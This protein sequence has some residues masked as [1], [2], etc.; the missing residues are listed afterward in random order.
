MKRL[1]LVII[2]GLFFFSNCSKKDLVSPI[3]DPGPSGPVILSED[4]FDSYPANTILTNNVILGSLWYSIAESNQTRSVVDG[5]IS[6]SGA[7]SIRLEAINSN[8]SCMLLNLGLAGNI[9]APIFIEGYCRIT[10]ANSGI[11]IAVGNSGEAGS[12][13]G[14]AGNSHGGLLFEVLTNDL[15]TGIGRIAKTHTSPII[16]RSWTKFLIK[17]DVVNRTYSTWINGGDQQTGVFH[18]PNSGIAIDYIG[19]ALKSANQIG[20]YAIWYDSIKIYK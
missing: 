17:I 5:T 14:L 11:A 3:T 18:S 2:C 13:L 12:T 15:S 6:Q 1:L 8:A 9:T 20:P 4:G 7:N 10:N 16:L 19:I